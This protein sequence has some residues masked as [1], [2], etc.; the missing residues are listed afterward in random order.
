[1]T[2]T[3]WKTGHRGHG[4]GAC[5]GEFAPGTTVVSALFEGPPPRAEDEPAADDAPEDSL[6]ED[7]PSFHRTDF[8]ATCFDGDADTGAPFSWWRAVVPPPEEKKAA[9][10]LGVAREFLVRLLGEDDEARAPL[11]YLLTLLLMRKRVVKVTE[12]FNDERGEVM[13]IRFPPGDTIHEVVCVELGEEETETLRV[14]LGEL[15]DLG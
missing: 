6:D 3:P 15:F 14:Q 10:D 12:H 11:R 7:L 2:A 5:A 13:S 1:M 8:C 9:F 4:C